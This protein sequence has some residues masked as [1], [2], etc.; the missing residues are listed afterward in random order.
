MYMIDVCPF[1]FDFEVKKVEKPPTSIVGT[2]DTIVEKSGWFGEVYYNNN[3]Y[4]GDYYALYLK[5]EGNNFTHSIYDPHFQDWQP[6]ILKLYETSLDS[7]GR[8]TCRLKNV[9]RATSSTQIGVTILPEFSHVWYTFS[10]DTMVENVDFNGQK[11]NSYTRTDTTYGKSTNTTLYGIVGENIYQINPIGVVVDDPEQQYLKQITYSVHLE[12][13]DMEFMFDDSFKTGECTERVSL[14]FQPSD[15][16]DSCISDH[17]PILKE[18]VPCSF[19]FDI[20]Y[21]YKNSSVEINTVGY[22]AVYGKTMASYR[23][24]DIIFPD[25]SMKKDSESFLLARELYGGY[26]KPFV[27]DAYINSDKKLCNKTQFTEW[28]IKKQYSVISDVY[29]IE[30]AA[31]Y[32]KKQG[33]DKWKGVDCESYIS[34]LEYNYRTKVG[35]KEVTY[36]KDDSIIAVSRIAKNYTDSSNP[37]EV[38]SQ[39]Y[40]LKYVTPKYSDLVMPERFE[41]CEEEAYGMIY[42]EEECD[43]PASTDVEA[44]TITSV[45]ASVLVLMMVVTSFISL[46]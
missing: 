9:R 42:I 13:R 46:F 45:V 23:K 16:W 32:V 41:K 28:T 34:K 43:V 2:R 19:R 3:A 17:D 7:D 27:Y 37:T 31:T 22:D 36:V 4:Y 15:L 21:T 29:G 5:G 33:K 11:C 25:D 20:N 24:G 39:Q 38:Y 12:P 44:A 8:K 10:Y 40:D 1:I 26:G 18:P 35:V 14:F 6:M 30:T